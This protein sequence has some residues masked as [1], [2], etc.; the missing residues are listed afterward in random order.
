MPAL[1]L[2]AVTTSKGVAESPDAVLHRPLRYLCCPWCGPQLCAR[3][4]FIG[5]ASPHRYEWVNAKSVD[6]SHH[7]PE[8]RR[9][10]RTIVRAFSIE[11][12]VPHFVEN[13]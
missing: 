10:C 12:V 9:D 4:R 13:K 11:N 2:R 1:G 5:F 6:L 8:S 7:V 3:P